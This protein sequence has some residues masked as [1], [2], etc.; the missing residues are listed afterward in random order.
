MHLIVLLEV[1][2]ALE[3][4]PVVRQDRAHHAAEVAVFGL[5]SQRHFFN[6]IIGVDDFQSFAWT[7]N[8]E[9]DEL[10]FCPQMTILAV[11]ELPDELLDFVR[12]QLGRHVDVFA[13]RQLSAVRPLF[14]YDHLFPVV[15][16]VSDDKTS[17][18]TSASSLACAATRETF[19]MFRSLLVSGKIYSNLI[20]F[21]NLPSR[22]LTLA[23]MFSFMLDSLSESSKIILYC[24]LLTS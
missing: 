10:T 1:V 2:S 18:V 23:T 6:F 12:R 17:S 3:A 4:A 21:P 20:I 22:V 9:R 7:Q 5:L 14:A 24:S 15:A 16:V 11:A 13:R 19:V 8:L